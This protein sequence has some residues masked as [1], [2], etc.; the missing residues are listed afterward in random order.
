MK[1]SDDTD[2]V[3]PPPPDVK[4]AAKLDKGMSAPAA[5]AAV[6]REKPRILMG[7]SPAALKPPPMILPPPSLLS[8]TRS[9]DC[10]FTGALRGAAGLKVRG[11]TS[12]WIFGLGAARDAFDALWYLVAV[13]VRLSGRS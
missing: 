5:S 8:I 1:P 13:L 11:A 2:A 7:G 6:A 12:G 9:R 4:K 3:P 10:G